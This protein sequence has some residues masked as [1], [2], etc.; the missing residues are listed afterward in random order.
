MKSQFDE[1]EEFIKNEIA[2]IRFKHK[3]HVNVKH[4]QI[5]DNEGII[6]GSSPAHQNIS[7]KKK[8]EIKESIIRAIIDSSE[9][10]I[11]SKTLEGIITSWNPSATKMF[12]F[13][14][15][16]AIGQHISIIVPPD[17]S[18]EEDYFN[19]KIKKG[20]KIHHFETIRIAKDGS[21][22]NIELSISPVKS[23]NGEINGLSHIV[24]DITSKNETEEKKATLAAIVASS[25]DAIISKTTNGTITSWNQSAT[26]MFGYTEKEAIGKHISLIIPKD[27]LQEENDI[28]KNIRSGKRIDHFETVRMAKDGTKKYISLTVSPI[29]NSKGIVIGASKIARDIS[30]KIE[31]ENKRKLYTERLKELNLYKDEFMVMASHELKTP[32]TV[33]LANLEILNL[34]MKEDPNSRFVDKTIE[35]TLKLSRLIN[36]LFEISKIQA[37][38]FEMNFTNFDVNDLVDEIIGSLQET[39]KIHRLCYQ[40]KPGITVDADRD[41]ISRVMVNFIGNALKYMTQPGDIHIKIEK[42]KN[43]ILFSV[44]DEGVGIPA[45]DIERI[46]E[47]FYRVSGSASSFSGSGIGLYISAEIIKAHFGKIWAES[48]LGKGSTFYFSIPINRRVGKSND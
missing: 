12:G 1:E 24:K 45:K 10:A 36:N 14:E 46:F 41:K 4:S 33:I 16:E 25:D 8:M 38:K 17:R 28:L 11:I 7:Q 6:T 21:Q 29:K 5:K 18:Q 19:M 35:Q 9:D 22:R 48:E 13:T 23:T 47:R 42:T 40:T 44:K 26:K 32:L 37:G 27:R 3:I 31:A 34:L 30:D 20:E 2:K 39:T 43:N 15:T